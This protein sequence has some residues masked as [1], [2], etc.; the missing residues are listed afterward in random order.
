MKALDQDRRDPGIP[1][2]ALPTS[3]PPPWRAP[4][5][6]SFAPVDAAS[7]RLAAPSGFCCRKPFDASATLVAKSRPVLDVS[8]VGFRI[9]FVPPGERL[10]IS[11]LRLRRSVFICGPS[12]RIS[13]QLR[14]TKLRQIAADCGKLHLR[15]TPGGMP[16]AIP[17]LR[18]VLHLRSLHHGA[19]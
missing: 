5:S 8:P 18:H 14:C 16:L 4:A 15:A 13:H 7:A 9:C 11:D 17:V 19:A 3:D 1:A 6:D 2:P 12:P 10:R